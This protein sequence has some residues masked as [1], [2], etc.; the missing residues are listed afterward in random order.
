M[1]HRLDIR[2]GTVVHSQ[3]RNISNPHKGLY[4]EYFL[5]HQPLL[6]LLHYISR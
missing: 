6:D 1:I 3:D 4:M 2:Q 5:F